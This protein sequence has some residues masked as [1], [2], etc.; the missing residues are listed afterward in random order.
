MGISV[1][2]RSRNVGTESTIL[3][4]GREHIKKLERTCDFFDCVPYLAVVV[5]AAD[6]ITTFIVRIRHYLDALAPGT[7][8]LY[9][10]MRAKA[11]K[12]YAADPEVFCFRFKTETG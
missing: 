5:D 8:G 11:L 10:S 1:K 12:Q 9:W 2:S 4:I 6:S 7:R 3:S